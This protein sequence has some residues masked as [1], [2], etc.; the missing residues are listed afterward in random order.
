MGGGGF[1]FDRTLTGVISD[2][3]LNT[4]AIAAGWDGIKPLLVNLIIPAGCVIHGTPSG[5]AYAFTIPGSFPV[6]SILNVEQ[7]GSIIGCGG[8]NG[9]NGSNGGN[10]KD[11]LQVLYP[12]NWKGNGLIGGGG[13]GG[14]GGASVSMTGPNGNYASTGGSAGVGAGWGGA[15][16]GSIGARGPVVSGGQTYFAQGGKGGD[17]GAPG[18]PGSPGAYSD[19]GTGTVVSQ[20]TPGTGG[21]PGRAIVGM[22]LISF[23]DSTLPTIA[24][25]VVY[26]STSYIA[27][28]AA[29]PGGMGAAF[30][31]GTYGGMMWGMLATSATPL[32]ITS[33]VPRTLHVPAMKGSPMV[34]ANQII[35]LVSASTP[36]RWMQGTVAGAANGNLTLN[37]TSQAGGGNTHSDWVVQSRFRVIDAPKATETTLAVAIAAL[38]PGA[39]NLHEPG[40]VGAAMR[41]AG[42]AADFPA[43]HWAA[44]QVIGGFSGWEVPTRDYLERRHRHFKATSSSNYITADRP[45]APSASYGVHGSVADVSPSHGVNTNTPDTGTAYTATSPGLVGAGVGFRAGEAQAFDAVPYLSSTAYDAN[46][47]W[48]QSFDPA[49]SYGRQYVVSKSA[50]LRIRLVRRS[51]I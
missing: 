17:G 13:G 12:V 30:E 51:I 21:Q 47:V 19:T 27:T 45:A 2:Y 22:E 36:S 28:P 18:F 23:V 39:W 11:A 16:T 31:G 38:P 10:G 8:V 4:A 35:R 6:G 41:S 49:T 34:Y 1:R 26:N 37:I 24:G 14:G 25:T 40:M 33:G 7:I 3:N 9:I 15:L 29:T 42:S 43:A 20:G 50:A 5:A 48:A 46:N 44:A 32:S